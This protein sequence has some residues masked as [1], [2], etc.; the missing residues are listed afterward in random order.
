M[1]VDKDLFSSGSKVYHPDNCCILL[2]GLNNL[3][4]NCKKAY[5]EG[6]TEENTLPLGV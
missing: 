5:S 6:Q 1:A 2:Q 4:V 3:L